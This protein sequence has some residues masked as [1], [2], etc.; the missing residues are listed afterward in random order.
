MKVLAP[1]LLILLN[2]MPSYAE[3]IEH[4]TIESV[5]E[6]FEQSIQTKDKARFLNLFVD[7]ESTMIAVVSD[8]VMDRRR[9]YV[10]EINKK[11][12]KNFVA[13]RTWTSTPLKMIDSVASAKHHSRESFD[14]IKITTDGNIAS[15]Y[16]DYVFYKDDKKN[17]WG[18]E[19]WQLVQT[20]KGWKISS[21]NY[22]FFSDAKP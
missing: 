2:C 22:S 16:F 20:V 3:P 15:V 9:A 8:A 18:S 14:N 12:N 4:Q 6:A 1:S 5:I 7:P 13:T 10:E 17:N 11:D 21:V 19:S